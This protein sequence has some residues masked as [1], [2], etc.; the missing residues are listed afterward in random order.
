[1]NTTKS[2]FAL[3]STNKIKTAFPIEINSEIIGAL[4]NA[5]ESVG[6]NVIPLVVRDMGN[7]FNPEYHLVDSTYQQVSILMALKVLR[8]R[9]P[10]E[11][12]NCSA[13]IVNPIGSEGERVDRAQAIAAQLGLSR[14]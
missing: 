10:K 2:T 13:I 14:P 5:I 3:V 6:F 1:M 12:G 4:A 11:W 9:S 8:E 7:A